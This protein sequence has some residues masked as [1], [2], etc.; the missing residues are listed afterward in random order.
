MNEQNLE[1]SICIAKICGEKIDE[2][3]KEIDL[4][5][6]EEKLIFWGL[7]LGYSVSVAAK[8]AGLQSVLIMLNSLKIALEQGEIRTH[9]H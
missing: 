3:V 6:D 7:F 2:M 5:T 4:K 9:L 1:N 8:Q